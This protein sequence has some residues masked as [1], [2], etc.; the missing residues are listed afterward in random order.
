MHTLV[1]GG[2]TRNIGK[3]ALVVDIIRAFPDAGW[4]AVKLTQHGHGLCSIN[5]KECDCAPKEHSYALDEEQDRS[6]HTDTSRFLVAGAAR[7]IWA[8]ARQGCLG[9]F[10]P[11]LR[12][13]LQGATNVIIE[14]NS[15][16]EFIQPDLYLVVLDPGK[17][18]FKESARRFLHRADALILR[19][20]LADA[21]W[22]RSDGGSPLVALRDLEGKPRFD[23]P[24][25]GKL[26]DELVELIQHR[27]FQVA[28]LTP[29]GSTNS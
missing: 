8:R 29:G 7:S 2:H 4:T 24:L 22:L 13:E 28:H 11:R 26:P 21:P 20:P 18:D 3:T 19:S 17:S 16:L 14:S 5:G 12:A 9:D 25:G 27:F 23:Q 10:V 1:V 15:L 6:N